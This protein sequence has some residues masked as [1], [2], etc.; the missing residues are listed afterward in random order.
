MTVAAVVLVRIEDEG[1]KGVI[2]GLESCFS[3]LLSSLFVGV[4]PTLMVFSYGGEDEE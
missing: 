1:G 4:G 3:L 2:P